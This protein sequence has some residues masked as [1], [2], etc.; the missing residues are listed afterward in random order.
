MVRDVSE[1]DILKIDEQARK[2]HMSRNK[3]IVSQL[4][5]IALS[6]ELFSKDDR[7]EKL[8]NATMSE[9]KEYRKVIEENKKVMEELSKKL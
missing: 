5:L 3:Y 4:H 9:I 2:K 7:Y 8:V 1:S 6:P